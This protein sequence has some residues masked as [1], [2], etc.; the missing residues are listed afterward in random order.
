[1]VGRVSAA[2][3]EYR[4]RPGPQFGMAWE[5]MKGPDGFGSELQHYLPTETSPSKTLNYEVV[6]SVIVTVLTV[7]KTR[8]S[9]K[10]FRR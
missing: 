6:V 10:I 4:P 5:N 1:M 2:G 9:A 8:Q 7:I 3:R